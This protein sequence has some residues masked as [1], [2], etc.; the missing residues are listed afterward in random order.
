MSEKISDEVKLFGM[1]NLMLETELARLEKQGIDIGHLRTVQKDE[2]VEPELFDLDIRKSANKMADFYVIYYCFEN[3]VRRLI[4]ETLMEE[5]KQDW[6]EKGV[7]QG[8]RDN[9]KKLQ[10]DEKETVMSIRS[11]D[12]QLTYTNFGELIPIIESNWHLFSDKIR[13]KKAMQQTLSQF[14]KTR[15]LIA[16]SCELEKDE[17]IRLELLVRDWQRIQT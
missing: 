13:S 2:N 7:P 9:V 8:I 16:H 10:E 11:N 1:R 6:W 5:H 17:V 14:N 15:N 12:D 3:S 4:K